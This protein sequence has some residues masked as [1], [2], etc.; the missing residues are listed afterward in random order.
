MDENFMAEAI[1]LS[2]D[3]M[4]AGEGGPFGAVVVRNGKIVSRG[5]NLVTSTNDPTA[6]AE[7]VAI[8]RACRELDTFWLGDC[9]L[10]VNCEPCPMCLAAVYWAGIR[11][12]YFG[13]LRRDAADAGF[14]DAYIAAELERP[15]AERDMQVEQ[16]MRENALEAFAIWDKMEDKVE[17]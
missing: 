12:I 8:R 16:G 9:E 2:I 5:W 14:G 10:Y 13:A 4:G 6:H 15:A 1:R 17:Y 7:I 11:K 3:K